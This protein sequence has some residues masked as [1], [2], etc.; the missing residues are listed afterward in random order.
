VCD[1]RTLYSKTDRTKCWT[2]VAVTVLEDGELIGRDPVNIVVQQSSTRG[3]ARMPRFLRYSLRTLF[4]VVTVLCTWFAWENRRERLA[5][6]QNVIDYA[7]VKVHWVASETDPQKKELIG[8][9]SRTLQT[10][11]RLKYQFLRPNGSFADGSSGDQY[12]K[13]LLARFSDTKTDARQTADRRVG[14]RRIYYQAIRA[15]PSCTNCHSNT[16]G[17]PSAPGDLVAIIKVE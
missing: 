6:Y 2:G 3:Q 12:E 11:S 8:E 9:M 1:S 14:G 15:K 7:L 17:G 4:V 5:L 13:S 10:R 16:T